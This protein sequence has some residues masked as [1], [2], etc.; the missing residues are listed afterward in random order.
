[1]PSTNYAYVNGR[2]M[3]EAE[4][5]VSI[6]DRGFLYGDG[7]FE[8]M[9]VY[10]GKVFRLHAHLERLSHG[11]RELVIT[12]PDTTEGFQAICTELID[13]NGIEEGVARIYVTRGRSE[14]GLAAEPLRSATVIV[15]VRNREFQMNPPGL[16]VVTAA[17]RI[18]TTSPLSRLKTA[19]RLP[20]VMAR[21]A[22]SA[23]DADE[24]VLVNTEGKVV[25]FTASNLF[26]VK[27]DEL[28]TPPLTDG[29]L[30]GITRQITLM[31]AAQLGVPASE[32]SFEREFLD[33]VDAIFATNSLIEIEY[34]SHLGNR[35]LQPH[36]FLWKKLLM[37]YRQLVRE[38]LQ[39]P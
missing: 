22:A 14:I 21:R 1:M 25:E 27:S 13:R 8:T 35:S 34:V 32:R 18:D 2:F 7:V 3:P 24:A 11:L 26:V 20:H 38:E 15:T 19:N 4:A 23:V 5:T 9:R 39:L 29:P 31:L 16:Y 37:A 30:P 10:R 6:F 12:C 28:T 17:A 36:P 33:E